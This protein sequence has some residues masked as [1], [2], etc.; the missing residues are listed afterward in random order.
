MGSRK[1][2][3]DKR[4]RAPKPCGV[5]TPEAL[6]RRRLAM[7]DHPSSATGSDQEVQLPLPLAEIHR[8]PLCSM[9]RDSAGRWSG[10]YRRDPQTAWSAF[11]HVQHDT[12]SSR[13][14]L[15]LDVDR[16]ASVHEA[17]DRALLPFPTVLLTRA[18]NGHEAA[19][20]V[21]DVPVHTHPRARRRP[22]DCLARVSE[23]FAAVSGA[24]P[25]YTGLLF[26]N[27]GV[28][29]TDGAFIVEESGRTWPLLELL[30]WV[31]HGW[32]RP[33]RAKLR[34]GIGRNQD[35]FASSCRAAGRESVSDAELEA[36][37]W[38]VNME[39]GHPLS[40]PEV[41]GVL[42]NVRKY[43]ER[44]AAR[45]WHSR[46]FLRRQAARGARG[47]RASGKV[48]A[49][50]AVTSAQ[51]ALELRGEGLTYRAIAAELGCSKSRAHVLVHRSQHQIE[52][53]CLPLGSCL[54]K[55][56]TKPTPETKPTPGRV[57]RVSVRSSRQDA[58]TP[59]VGESEATDRSCPTAAGILVS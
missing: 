38:S 23:Y 53:S 3:T 11:R 14:G 37:A 13:V 59:L 30:E 19:A 26:R 49:S 24:D 34:T 2:P 25:G 28:A 40:D 21:L 27:A 58:S 6:T 17:V 51:A 15:F 46:A 39:F 32:R 42:R 41:E 20:W 4:S 16:I 10:T 56:A 9:G 33:T 54:W 47:G 8:R 48:R 29:K 22:M 1:P 44:W 52:G 50:K 5:S 35:L 55:G 43:R 45:G 18:A 7:C 57:G 12:G 36:L 31:P